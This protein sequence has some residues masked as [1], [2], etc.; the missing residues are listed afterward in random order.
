MKK[1]AW[2]LTALSLS[3]SPVAANP[4]VAVGGVVCAGSGLC[5]VV[6]GT[7][8]VA[9][10][11]YAIAQTKSG[12]QFRVAIGAGGQTP[13]PMPS[14]Q[15]FP[16]QFN[17]E[18]YN[19]PGREVHAAATYEDCKNMLERFRRQGRNLKL[20]ARINPN[21]SNRDNPLR[22]LCIFTGGDAQNNAFEDH[23]YNSREEYRSEPVRPTRRPYRGNSQHT[24][25]RTSGRRNFQ[26]W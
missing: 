11:T 23:R 19:E 18:N 10:T 24:K 8:I 15:K 16:Q 26:G 17:N 20:T 9:G 22:W 25:F 2:L 7:A 4:A 6:V 14:R 13:T 21:A 1:I 5:G 3:P 12:I